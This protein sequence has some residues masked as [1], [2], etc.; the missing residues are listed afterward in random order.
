MAG[1]T[2]GRARV[3]AIAIAAGV[4]L[5]GALGASGSATAGPNE[6]TGRDRPPSAREV[7]SATA[8]FLA[9]RASASTARER[10]LAPVTPPPASLFPENRVVSYYGAPQLG[11]TIVGRNSPDA[12]GRKLLTQA[13]AY[14]G[15]GLRPVIPA[16]DLI[17]VIATRSRGPDRK[18]RTRQSP[19]VIE[20]YLAEAR[21]IGARLMLDIQP[22]RANPVAEVKALRTWLAQP[23]VDIAIDPEWDVSRRGVPGRSPGSTKARKLNRISKLMQGI[24]DAKGLPAKQL[25]VHQFH[26]RSVRKKKRLRE[27]PDVEL[28][29]NFDGI[30]SP[31]AKKAGYRRL[32]KRRLFNGFSLFYRLDRKLMSPRAVLRLDPEPDF[33]L[34]Q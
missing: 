28:T 23:D 11:K 2:G 4:S 12:A 19:Q 7:R 15:T 8:R 10:R 17:G 34:Y 31:R 32:S 29:L 3:A 13:D 21:E 18:Y 22:G 16:F 20:S 9:D 30:G 24:I 33:V 26:R 27:R 6:E 25:L 5:L 1:A 14:R